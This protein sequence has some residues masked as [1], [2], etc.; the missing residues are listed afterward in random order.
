MNSKLEK[1]YSSKQIQALKSLA[2]I[3]VLHGA[4]RAGKTYILLICFLL[5]VKK[6]KNQK[7]K[8]II[9]GA[10]LATI[11]SNILDDLSMILGREIKLNKHNNFELFGNTVLVRPGM[12]SDSWKTVRGFTAYGAL[13][14]EGT[15]LNDKYIKEVIS[16]CSGEG[17]RIF[18]DTNPENPTHTIKVDYIDKSGQKLEDGQLNIEAIHFKLDDNVFLDPVYVASVKLST[19]TGLFYDRD[20]EG[21]WVNAQGVVY[22]DFNIKTMVKDTL[23]RFQK[24]IAGLDWGYEHPGTL[25]V[26]GITANNEYW[27]IDETYEQHQEIDFWVNKAKEKIK[28]YGKIPF[29][30]DSAR[31]EHVARFLREGFYAH[32]ADKSILSGIEEVAKQMKLQKF[33]VHSSCENFINEICNYVW[34]D[35]NGLPVKANDDAQDAIRYAIYTYSKGKMTTDY[36]KGIKGVNYLDKRTGY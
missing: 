33:Y 4:K 2:R 15:A 22:K 19:P 5:L 28:M 11:Q 3:L 27:V 9:G 24:Y 14:N 35:K 32:N 36:Y 21:L 23:P 8:F 26:I 12:T 13:L 17:A 34:D 20:I 30:C 6:H 25:Y 18:I 10:S 1:I 7:V 29:Y 16:R 31:P